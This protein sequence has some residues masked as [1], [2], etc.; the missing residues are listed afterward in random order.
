MASTL[1]VG[2]LR[3]KSP[4]RPPGHTVTNAWGFYLEGRTGVLRPGM[5]ADVAIL[6]QDLTAIAPAAIKDA[7]VVA[8]VV[9]G[10]VVFRR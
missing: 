3:R 10:R 7:K 1:A 8:T 4:E 2:C 5:Q 6:D 9:G